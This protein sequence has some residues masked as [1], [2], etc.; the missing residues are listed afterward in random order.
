MSNPLTRRLGSS[1]QL[2]TNG[3]ALMMNV[4]VGGVTGFLFWIIAAR[5]APASSVG[6]AAA[7]ITAMLGGLQITQSGIAANVPMMLTSSPRPGWILKQ[8][9]LATTLLILAASTAYVLIAPGLASGLEY[10]RDPRLVLI[11]VAGSALWGLFSLQDGALSGILKGHLV[12]LENSVW[13]V[14]RLAAVSMLPLAVD[15][16]TPGWILATWLVPALLM[17]IVVNYYL[18]VPTTAPLRHPRGDHTH[19][20]RQLLGHMGFETLASVGTGAV[21]LALPAIVLTGVGADAAAPF[22]VAYSF[23]L[24]GEGALGSFTA[25]YAIEIRRKGGVDRTQTRLTVGVLALSSML[26]IVA[27]VLLGRQ[28]MALLGPEYESSGAAVLIILGLGLPFRSITLLSGAI[29][30]VAGEGWRNALQQG[31]FVAVCFLAIWIL[32]TDNIGKLAMALVLGRV[33]A[34][35]IALVHLRK[36]TVTRNFVGSPTLS[37]GE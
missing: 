20:P 31:A 11:F 21:N 8:A 22:F 24:V 30:R 9:Y 36:H 2:A 28:L 10:L 16:I 6:E 14:L 32:G 35:T 26:A 13:G 3:G 4:I 7:L 1:K 19:P 27:V 34:A 23:I 12:L 25:A 37:V 29:N 17:V 18:Y 33:A 5:I 15:A